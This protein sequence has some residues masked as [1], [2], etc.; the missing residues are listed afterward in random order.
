MCR[1]TLAMAFAALGRSADAKK[2]LDE[3]LAQSRERYVSSTSLALIQQALGNFDEAFR[4][5]DRAIDNRDGFVF[6]IKVS[7]LHDPLRGDLRFAAL[8]KKLRL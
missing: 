7:P 6:S 1:A 3:L 2:I 8:L 5:L 4:F